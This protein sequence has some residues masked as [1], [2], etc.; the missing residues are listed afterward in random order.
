MRYKQLAVKLFVIAIFA[1]VAYFNIVGCGSDEKL[2]DVE[3]S[4]TSV[5][6]CDAEFEARLCGGINCTE[7]FPAL[8]QPCQLFDCL[9]NC[10]P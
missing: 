7:F 9:V 3:F 10:P 4:S 6:G 8:C 2:C 5:D 1:S